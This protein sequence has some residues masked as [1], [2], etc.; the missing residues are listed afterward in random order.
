MYQDR[1]GQTAQW[2]QVQLEQSEDHLPVPVAWLPHLCRVCS[3]ASQVALL[4]SVLRHASQN[5]IDKDAGPGFTPVMIAEDFARETGFT[6]Q[7]MNT[8]IKDAVTR[9]LIEENRRSL[10]H[11]RVC[12]EN[13]ASLKNGYFYRAEPGSLGDILGCLGLDH[14]PAEVLLQGQTVKLRKLKSE[15]LQVVLDRWLGRSQA[16]AERQAVL[17]REGKKLIRWMKPFGR[18]A[19][20]EQVV[21]TRAKEGAA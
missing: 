3:G 1:K 4:L 10:H 21:R 16:A 14:L 11:Y 12:P 8:V 18:E 6:K 9:K 20:V 13:W 19:T 15:K 7:Q 17:A 2:V 5:R